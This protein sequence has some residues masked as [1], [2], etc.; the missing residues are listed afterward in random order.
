LGP[1]IVGLP[2][3]TLSDTKSS[4]IDDPAVTITSCLPD[5]DP[6]SPQNLLL[7]KRWLGD[8]ASRQHKYRHCP[9]MMPVRTKLPTRVVY[10]GTDDGQDPPRL[11]SGNGNIA[12]YTALTYC[13]GGF[14]THQTEKN[15]IKRYMRAL[16]VERLPKSLRDAILL[17]R[18]LGIQYIWIDSLCIIQDCNED[19]DREMARMANIYKNAIFTIAAARAESC[20][21]G[22]LGVQEMRAGLLRISIKLPMNCLNGA[23]GS[24]L[25]YLTRTQIGHENTPID[26]RAWSYQEQ[27]LS[28]RVISFFDDSIEWRCPSRHLSDD[29]LARKES[30]ATDPVFL[31]EKTAL[32]ERTSHMGRL[33][34]L[35]SERKRKFP[36]HLANLSTVWWTAVR[37]YTMG[38]LSNPDDR[39]P[40]IG[41]IASEFHDLSG[42]VYVAGLWMSNLI[43][44]LQW[45]VYKQLEEPSNDTGNRDLKYD[46]PTWTWAST[47]ECTIWKYSEWYELDSDRVKIIDCKANPVSALAPFGSV[48]GGELR[49]RAP[50]KL[51]SDRQVKE[52]LALGGRYSRF[53]FGEIFFDRESRRH[54]DALITRR[55]GAAPHIESTGIWF[56]GLSKHVDLDYESSGL[57]LTKRVDGLFE[58]I[59]VFMIFVGDAWLGYGSAEHDELRSSWGDDYVVTDVTIV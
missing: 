53:S 42:D 25:L 20:D 4:S 46:T 54:A 47:H 57:V 45:S 13:W 49:I 19:K 35:H 38:S 59:G 31:D 22:F 34:C 21:D 41:G 51:L 48:N 15:R 5:A 27:L 6:L 14:Q 2:L 1:L 10:V 17:T 23:I 37:E 11:Y 16:P 18:A 8:C 52:M 43:R 9:N 36:K 40:A 26:K 3:L 7:L 39:L 56:L 32:S 30:G 58:R 44:D 28:R 50:L 33:L 29:M 12:G 55:C 24:V